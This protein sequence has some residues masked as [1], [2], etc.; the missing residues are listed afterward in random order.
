MSFDPRVAIWFHARCPHNP[1][2]L[3]GTDSLPNGFETVWR[4]PD[5]L[6]RANP[7]FLAVDCRDLACASAVDWRA[8]GKPLLSW[9]I[10][11]KADRDA[12][13]PL[14]DALIAEAEGL[15]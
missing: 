15:S 3:V 14:A 1:I 13:R 9:T 12:A 7:D 4:D 2:G 8:S 11:T 6:A 5:I 10:R